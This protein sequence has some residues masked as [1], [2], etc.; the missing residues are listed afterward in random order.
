M[1]LFLTLGCITMRTVIIVFRVREEIACH[2]LGERE[3]EGIE[4]YVRTRN[5]PF[6]GLTLV[7]FPWWLR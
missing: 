5:G 3:L 7:G 2:R 4:K 6:L 1:R